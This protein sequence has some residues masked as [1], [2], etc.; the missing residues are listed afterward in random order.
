M[1][2]LA[3]RRRVE[4]SPMW[5]DALAV[6]G[7][8]LRI[9]IRS[10]VTATQIAPYALLVLVLFGL[11][12]DS[13]HQILSQAAPGL[14]WVAV[15]LCCLLAVGRSYAIEQADAATDGLRASGV[16]PAGVFLGKAA[17]IAVELLLL[18]VLLGA[19]MVVLFDVRLHDA[20]LLVLSSV[21]ATVAIAAAA[22]VYG[23]VSLGL[24]ARETLLPLL[25]LPVMA[26]VVLAVTQAWMFA[27]GISQN[28]G[29]RWLGLLGGFAVL[30]VTFGVL[31]FGTLMEDA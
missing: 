25:L 17:A 24:R 31:A 5:R 28:P 18:E 27:L 10:R 2:T 30:Y 20:A 19:G 23:M 22:T 7:K 9:E 6:G 16:D 11:A 15:L 4:V 12:F 29:W 3:A 1:L 13:N 26:P 14:F 21:A 8:D